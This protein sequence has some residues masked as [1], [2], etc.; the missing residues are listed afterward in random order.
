MAGPAFAIFD[1][2]IGA[3][4]I[5]W[6][7]G[8]VVATALPETDEAALVCALTRRVPGAMRGDMPLPVAELAETIITHLSGGAIDYDLSI[9]DFSAV[10]PFE[11]AVYDATFAIPRGE[12]RT[13]G[14]L[15]A[16]IGQPGAARAI[17]RALG[18]NPFPIVIPCHR[19]LAA[20][21]R[22]GGFSAPGGAATKMRLLDIEGARREGEEAGLFDALPWALKAS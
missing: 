8:A 15:G 1:T 4:G 6:K 7:D 22:S 12:T 10:E 16:A 19:I 2:P 17:G 13:Y 20:G 9:L 11:K 18:R 5:V 3:C 14:A 21:G